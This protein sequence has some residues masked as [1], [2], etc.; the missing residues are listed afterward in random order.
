VY[1]LVQ[2]RVADATP[3]AFLWEVR[4]VSVPENSDFGAPLEVFP[5]LASADLRQWV[6]RLPAH[7]V[8]RYT[9][10]FPQSG[11]MSMTAV[12]DRSLA[13]TD[14]FSRFCRSRGVSFSVTEIAA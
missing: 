8:I 12:M 9:V 6:G 5:S 3:A 13:A 4:Q 11:H 10:G 7:S 2:V 14:D 1:E